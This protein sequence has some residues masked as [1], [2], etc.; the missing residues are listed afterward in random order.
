[1]L[2]VSRHKTIEKKQEAN[3]NKITRNSQIFLRKR[4]LSIQVTQI[5]ILHR[6]QQCDILTLQGIAL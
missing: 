5:S 3:Y 6:I 2:P 4:H 1:M